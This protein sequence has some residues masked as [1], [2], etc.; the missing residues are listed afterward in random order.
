MTTKAIL[1][2]VATLREKLTAV[3]KPNDVVLEHLDQVENLAQAL[4]TI[5]AAQDAF[6]LIDAQLGYAKNGMTPGVVRDSVIFTASAARKEALY[7][8]NRVLR[9][10]L[11]DDRFGLFTEKEEDQV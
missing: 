8:R 5:K 7:R 9:E 6:R 3:V 11:E 10:V 1:K 4:Q 2:R